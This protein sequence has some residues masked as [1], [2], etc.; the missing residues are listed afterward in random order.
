M[1][2]KRTLL[3]H[4]KDTWMNFLSLKSLNTPMVNSLHPS[5]TKM[6]TR[7]LI[8]PLAKLRILLSQSAAWVTIKIQ[9]SRVKKI[10]QTAQTLRRCLDSIHSLFLTWSRAPLILSTWSTWRTSGHIKYWLI[11]SQPSIMSSWVWSRKLMVK[12]KS[13]S[14]PPWRTNHLTLWAHSIFRLSSSVALDTLQV[15]PI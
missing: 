8:E 11:V 6:D 9:T 3:R 5:L 7:L 4:R 15:S 12:F 13:C 1:T 2:Q 14:P 10:I